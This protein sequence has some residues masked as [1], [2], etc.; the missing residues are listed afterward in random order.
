[1]TIT[2]FSD[3]PSDTAI[4]DCRGTEHGDAAQGSGAFATA[5]LPSSYLLR[6]KTAL[7]RQV[8]H[9]AV[10]ESLAGSIAADA[11][12]KEE[13]T[14]A[15][16]LAYVAVL[17]AAIRETVFVAFHVKIETWKTRKCEKSEDKKRLTEE[18]AVEK[19][20]EGFPAFERD[21]AAQCWG[22]KWAI[23]LPAVSELFFASRPCPAVVKFDEAAF[24]LTGFQ[25]LLNIVGDIICG[26]VLAR[27]GI[28]FGR[29]QRERTAGSIAADVTIAAAFGSLGLA[30]TD[31]CL[32]G[33]LFQNYVRNFTANTSTT[34]VVP[35]CN[36]Y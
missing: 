18:E 36:H 5:A 32:F 10:S 14:S 27:Q 19:V 34:R 3:N 24:A 28:D 33:G 29:M 25:L 2:S 9:I 16:V 21:Y 31:T 20:R 26:V 30:M 4:S 6:L 23:L 22:C 35:A 13:T 8:Y 11:T 7:L 1:M 17:L 12:E 15:V